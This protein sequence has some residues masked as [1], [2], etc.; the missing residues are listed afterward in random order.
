MALGRGWVLAAVVGGLLAGAP[1]RATD[2]AELAYWQTIQ[3]STDPAE[4]KA[5]LDTY[6]QGTFA[7]LARARYARLTQGGAPAPVAQPEPEPA[8]TVDEKITVTPQPGRVGD[9][10]KFTCTNFPKPYYTDMIVVVRAG[11]PDT[12]PLSARDDLKLLGRSYPQNCLSN[13]YVEMGPFAPGRYEVRFVTAL[14]ND[15]HTPEIRTRTAFT[16]R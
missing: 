6:P 7:A 9:M 11:S 8:A 3:N 12:N 2:L 4:Y 15:D 16:V 14:Y 13:G 5:Y 10:L 1:A